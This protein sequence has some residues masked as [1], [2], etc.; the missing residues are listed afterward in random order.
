M[1]PVVQPLASAAYVQH[2]LKPEK[3]S[4]DSNNCRAFLVQCELHFVL[5]AAS[6][7]SAKKFDR[8]APGPAAAE[9]SWGFS[10]ELAL[11]ALRKDEPGV[12]SCLEEQM[13][14]MDQLG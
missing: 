1:V 11:L 7:P 2:L 4:G 6:F 12:E 10:R 3:F 14:Q 5:Q 9:L 8:T 13:D